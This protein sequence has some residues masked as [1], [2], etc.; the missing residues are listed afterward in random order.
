MYLLKISII[1]NV[2]FYFRKKK[3]QTAMADSNCLPKKQ[4][5]IF[6]KNIFGND[7]ENI[8]S[9]NKPKELDSVVDPR[10]QTYKLVDLDFNGSSDKEQ[11]N[12]TAEKSKSVIH[13]G[14][15]DSSDDEDNRNVFE[16]KLNDYGK[17]IKKM[18][19]KKPEKSSNTNTSNISLS[20]PK[21]S[22]KAKKEDSNEEIFGIY[23]K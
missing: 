15:T 17:S 2:L 8:N 14:D 18:I 3:N 11:L 1:K 23:I 5:Y 13:K 16:S 22:F 10:I 19:Y 4:K 21:H 12:E 7:E 9:A 20:V 6:N